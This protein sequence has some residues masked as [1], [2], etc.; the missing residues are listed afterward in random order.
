MIIEKNRTP[1]DGIERER[2]MDVSAKKGLKDHIF[3]VS[4]T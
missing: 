3:E 2:E 4:C 1:C